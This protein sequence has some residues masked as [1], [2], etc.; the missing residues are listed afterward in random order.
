MQGSQVLGITRDQ[1]D[2][3]AIVRTLP[4]A[5][6][7]LR[8]FFAAPRTMYTHTMAIVAYQFYVGDFCCAR[9]LRT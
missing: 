2:T 6:P 3:T 4:M 1:L 7:R 5:E 9:N 8:L